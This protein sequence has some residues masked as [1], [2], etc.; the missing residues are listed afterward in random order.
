M[1]TTTTWIC[2][3]C[4]QSITDVDQGWVEWLSTTDQSK[5]RHGRG[6]RLV[7]HNGKAN[8]QYDGRAEYQ[9]D[10]SILADNPLKCYL[11]VDGLNKLLS[12][13][14]AGEIDLKEVLEMTKR[15]HIPG[16]EHAR[17]FFEEALADE[18]IDPNMY[19]GYYRQTEIEAVLEFAA[20]KEES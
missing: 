17:A 7:H 16:Y 19:P 13:M 12:D 5:K 20:T 10:E 18:I 14:E 15:L 3:S 4:G 6:L 9:K 11:G 1:N 8:C 2:D